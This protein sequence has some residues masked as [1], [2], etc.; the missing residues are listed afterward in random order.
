MEQS[1]K[2]INGFLIDPPSFW[3][4][5]TARLVILFTLASQQTTDRL[6][7]ILNIWNYW[8]VWNI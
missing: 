5:T 6:I 8:N 4:N 2:L 3:L 1:V 7:L